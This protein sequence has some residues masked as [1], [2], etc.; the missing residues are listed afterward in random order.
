MATSKTDD[1]PA[2]D[3]F[4]NWLRA[5]LEWD[6]TSGLNEL[7]PKTGIVYFNGKVDDTPPGWWDRL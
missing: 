4:L 2:P 5:V 1:W 3:S 6:H 7:T